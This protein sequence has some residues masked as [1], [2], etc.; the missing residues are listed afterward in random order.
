M[1][2]RNRSKIVPTAR[3]RREN[4]FVSVPPRSEAETV[5]PYTLSIRTFGGVSF[6][7][8]PAPDRNGDAPASAH[9][10]HFETRT[11]QALLLYL[12]CQGR[13]VSRD[14]LAELLWP[15]RSQDQARANLR[16]ALHR[17]R[18]QV[19]PFLTVTRQDVGLNAGAA[20][21]FDVADFEKHLAAGQPEAA[22]SFY[23]GD[24]LDGFY[25]D[26]SPLFEQWALLERERL[27]SLALAAWQGLIEERSAAGQLPAAIDASQRLLQLDSLHEVTHR[28]LMRL[29]AQSG[30]RGAALA[31]YESVRRLLHD[32]LAAPPEEA[33]T[34]LVEQIRA[35]ELDKESGRRGDM[36]TVSLSPLLPFSSSSLPPQP[37][38][39]IGREAELAQIRQMLAQPDCRL[40]TLLGVG[41]IGKTRLAIEA[42]KGL[43]EYTPPPSSTLPT[44]VP[45]ILFPDGIFFVGFAPIGES[46]LITIVLAQS[47]GLQHS[48]SDLLAQLAAY[49]QPKQLLLIL[50]NFE[51]IVEGRATIARLLHAAPGLKVLLTSRQRLALQEEWLLPVSGLSSRAG[52]GDDAGQLFLR[53]ARRVRPDFVRQG[54]EEAIAAICRQVEGMPL[55]LELAA[56]WVRVMPCVAIARQIAADL[57]FLTTSLHNLPQR[58]HSLRAIFDQSWRLLSPEEQRV[59]RRVV[60]FRGGWM[61]DEA[62]AVAEATLSLL[63]GLVDKSLLR[64]DAQ[65]RFD[66]HELVRQYAAEHL[67]ASGET[68]GL[69]RRH[70]NTYLEL[71]RT[72]DAHLRGPSAAIWYVRIDAE[73]DNL[74]AAWEWALAA[75]CWE[76]A[77]WL[78][79]ALSHFGSVYVQFQE[80]IFW[81]EQL[82]PHR[83]NL[84]HDLRLALLLA[85]YLFWRGQDD[86]ASIDG[87][88][89]ELRQLQEGSA[90]RSLQAVA[91]RCMAV[92]SADVAQAM[93]CWER[94]IGL[95][96]EAGDPQ[97]VDNTY[98]A[99][100]D[101]GYQ[102]AF[103]LFRYA[104]RLI[105]TGD[106]PEAERIAA[107]S[108]A[109]YRRRENRDYIVEP[110]CSLGRLALLRGDL[111]QARLL[112][113]E[114]VA[115]A[116]S[117]GNVLGLNNLLPRLGVVALYSGKPDEARRLLD[118]SLDLSRTIG[119]AMYLAWSYTY[120]ADTA[121]WQGE[122]EEAARWMAEALVHHARPR[123]L[124][125]ETVDCLWVAAR[126]ATAQGD[127]PRA[128]ALFGLAEQM[129]QRIG[130]RAPSPVRPHIDAA[131][132][133]VQAAL[134]PAVY[135]QSFAAGQSMTL[136]EGF[137][138]LFV[139]NPS[140]T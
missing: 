48:G 124:R 72:A 45:G 20:I 44:P 66:M 112:L 31:H 18:R 51:Q 87:Y 97:P 29:L 131:L 49:L 28:R 76:D 65:G 42:A 115:I 7:L 136:A 58:H 39:F 38:P 90:N 56:G 84:P 117:V 24:F 50:D 23:Q 106:Y 137:A 17:L 16:L 11:T 105:D 139:V 83:Q 69:R 118:E 77:A 43:I 75:G 2:A 78:G 35:G 73:L 61:P 10:L 98:S 46:E 116:R 100:S 101:S 111:A 22:T 89:A 113:Q 54:Q 88:M 79:V 114:G 92:A 96:R 8:R 134:D 62:V 19:E 123:W 15:E 34:E 6:A 55:A 40:L 85:L 119:S 128:A 99:F 138:A 13:A 108:L 135:A 5:A 60:L 30:Q 14:G 94:C 36:T 95:L 33:T 129:A 104:I 37:T 81:L 1:I 4:H 52:W 53:C 121:L 26:D 12:A 125:T 9:P 110:L 93:A 32:E 109:I 91:W 63:A 47:L 103:A 86:F 71:V 67:A 3:R 25:L 80:S 59:L 130:Y 82:L 70:F 64:V 27:R 133:T 57:D 68:D 21:E 140:R 74:R 41:G 107:E 122:V 132:A 126:L 127:Y 102:L 120:L